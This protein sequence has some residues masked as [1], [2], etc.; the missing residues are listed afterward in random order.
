MS[1]LPRHVLLP[2]NK[3]DHSKRAL[4]WYMSNV[5]RPNDQIHILYVSEPS[6]A[7]NNFS[8]T[9]IGQSKTNGITAMLQ[10]HVELA[11]TLSHDF[12]SKLEDRQV[13]GDFTLI[14]GNKPGEA[15]VNQARDLD[16]DLIVMG[17]RGSSTL[18][19]TVFGSVSDYVLH[20][21]GTPLTVIPPKRV[22]KFDIRRASLRPP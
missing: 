19:R 21:G 11:S 9:T 17:C 4:E 5:F 8:L 6:Y 22:E 2:V 3:N 14:V 15:I 16:A 10:E 1:D 18:K 7:A 20:H 12:I 13:P